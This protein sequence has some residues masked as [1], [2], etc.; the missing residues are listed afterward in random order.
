MHK[1][2]V[3][4]SGL[5]PVILFAG[6]LLS[7]LN[8]LSGLFCI[9][10]LSFLIY[11]QFYQMKV[12]KQKALPAFLKTMLAFVL[13][14]IFLSLFLIFWIINFGISLNGVQ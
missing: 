2:G 7:D 3:F 4:T 6:S 13:Y 11:F 12:K 10:F 9:A 8:F 1:W 5:L 14:G